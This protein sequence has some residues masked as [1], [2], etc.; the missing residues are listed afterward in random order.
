MT[1]VTHRHA[2]EIGYC[3]RGLRTWFVSV[4]LDWAE[5]LKNGITADTLRQYNNAM[6]ERVIAHAEEDCHG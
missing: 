4:G 1:T 2:R 3:N 5:F 6:A